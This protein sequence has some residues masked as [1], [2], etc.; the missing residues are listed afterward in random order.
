MRMSGA[1]DPNFSIGEVLG[2]L[3]MIVALAFVF[4]GI[5]SYRDKHKGGIISFKDAFFNGLIIV[6]VASVIYVLGWEIYYPNFWPDFAEQYVD[7]QMASLVDKGLSESELAS[8][9]AEMDSWAVSYKN[10]IIRMP[11]VFMEIFP[12]GLIIAIFSALILKK[13]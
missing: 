10:P 8:K 11:Q 5:R 4:V 6:L 12:V 7:G 13:K 2:Y 3:S 9:K 1:D